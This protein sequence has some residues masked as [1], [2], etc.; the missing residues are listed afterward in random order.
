L[1]EITALSGPVQ[2]ISFYLYLVRGKVTQKYII[3]PVI[4]AGP[5]LQVCHISL[6]ETFVQ[7]YTLMFKIY[8]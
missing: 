4:P 8:A 6:A 5:F 3:L 7:A 1:A 2:D